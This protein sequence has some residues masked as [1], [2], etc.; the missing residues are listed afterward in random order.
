MQAISHSSGQFARYVAYSSLLLT[1]LGEIFMLIEISLNR[2]RAIKL[3]SSFF[4]FGIVVKLESGWSV[5][6]ENY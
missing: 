5:E 2:L 3:D 6:E 4:A 1:I